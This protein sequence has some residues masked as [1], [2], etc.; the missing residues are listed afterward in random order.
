MPLIFVMTQI[1]FALFGGAVIVV[2]YKYYRYMLCKPSMQLL[3]FSFIF[4]IVPALYYQN[5]LYDWM[6][7]PLELVLWIDFYFV[8]T[9]ILTV[10]VANENAKVVYRHIIRIPSRVELNQRLLHRVLTLNVII[11]ILCSAYYLSV[12]EF[13]DTGLYA[14]VTGDPLYTL[15]RE[16]SLKLQQ[17]VLLKYSFTIMCSA[18]V[19]IAVASAVLL[20]KGSK[21]MVTRVVLVGVIGILMLAASLAG[22]RY[23]L[24][25]SCLLLLF[26]IFYMQGMVI[27]TRYLVIGF[28]LSIMLPIMTILREGVNLDFSTLILY[29]V[30]NTFQRIFQVPLETGAWHMDYATNNGAVGIAGIAKLANLFGIQA[31]N[32]PNVIGLNYTDTD[33]DSVNANTG[34]LFSYFAYFGWFALPFVVAMSVLLDVA[35]IWIRRWRSEVL[36]IAMPCLTLSVLSFMSSDFTTVLLSSGFLVIMFVMNG[37]DRFYTDRVLAS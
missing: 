7:N 26:I 12:V 15:I 22:T 2:I 4:Y 28:S 14:L 37:V 6:G 30:D 35:L 13:Y 19:P 25:A 34:F 8:L 10:F 27:K 33:V 31:I 11:V 1:A 18:F 32:L 23:N 29:L 20:F 36:L 21:G 5:E 9:L 17:S 3:I 16:N 24:I